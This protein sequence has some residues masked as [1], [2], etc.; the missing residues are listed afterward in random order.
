MSVGFKV[1]PY[2]HCLCTQA[3]PKGKV[4][5]DIFYYRQV[6][7]EM[8][9]RKFLKNK[10]QINPI[11]L[12]NYNSKTQ[13]EEKSDIF[14]EI[15]T[16]NYFIYKFNTYIKKTYDKSSAQ[17]IDT[18]L[19]RLKM[20]ISMR[21]NKENYSAYLKT[22][23][24]LLVSISASEAIK[25]FQQQIDVIKQQ[26]MNIPQPP[27]KITNNNEVRPTGI[28]QAV[29]IVNKNANRKK[30]SQVYSIN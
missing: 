19:D 14:Y 30:E 4:I 5:F 24:F 9:L 8:K 16:A 12:T 3:A 20:Y 17:L 10:K 27:S 18:S 26:Y 6:L 1:D 28:P 11:V 25:E 21:N 15:H 13:C 22:I 7:R 2:G 29:S 23:R